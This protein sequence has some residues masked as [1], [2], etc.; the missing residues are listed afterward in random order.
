M[1]PRDRNIR[2]QDWNDK[3]RKV[4]TLIPVRD[5][6]PAEAAYASAYVRP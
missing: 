5:V 3:G 6:R 4:S 1:L 2:L